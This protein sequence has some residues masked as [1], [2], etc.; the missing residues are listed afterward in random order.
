MSDVYD[1]DRE[2]DRLSK[3]LESLAHEYGE[4]DRKAINLRDQYELDKARK[5]ELAPKGTVPERAAWVKL[6]CQKQMIECHS[7]ESVKRWIEKRMKATEIN[8]SALQSRFRH[9][10]EEWKLINQRRT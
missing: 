10:E 9:A 6:Q 3:Q 2:L 4:A 1:I 8:M 5:L 7:A